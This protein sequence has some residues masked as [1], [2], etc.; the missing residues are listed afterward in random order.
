MTKL[1]P[2]TP[3]P[4]I[5]FYGIRH[6]GPGCARSLL[7]ALNAWNPDCVLIEGPPEA[8]FLLP[9]AVDPEMQPPVALL[10]HCPAEPLLAS[11]Y[12][13]AEFSPEWQA[14]VWAV[15]RG[16]DTRF[17][18]LPQTHG[19][20]MRKARHE[21]EAAKAEVEAKTENMEPAAPAEDLHDQA[22]DPLD[23]LAQAAGYG[24]GES[25]W[26][27]MVEERGDAVDLFA[28]IAEAMHEVRGQAAVPTG[29]RAEREDLREAHMR[30]CIRQAQTQGHQRI[31]VI[32]GAWH[33]PALDGK[34]CIKA[35]AKA[36]ANL[37]KGLPKLKVA[38]TWV[39]WSYPHLSAHSGYGAGVDSPGWYGYLWQHSAQ[40]PQ[41]SRAIGWLTQVAR[42]LREEGL[43]CSSAHVIEGVRLAETVA[44]LRN[45]PAPGL[46]ELNEACV[47]ILCHG[48]QAPLALIEK[49]LIV[50]NK[51]GQIPTAVPAVP[52]Q[53]D[54]EQQQKTLRLKPEALAK[55]L[56][57]DLRKESDLAKSR[58]LHRL[59]LLD[60]AWG[61]LSRTGQSS[62]GTFHEVWQL[63]RQPEF[64][65]NV[66]TASRWGNTLEQ[67]AIAM[68]GSQLHSSTT[69]TELAEL[70]DNVLLANLPAA[71]DAVA[72]A[73]EGRAAVTG[74]SAQLLATLPALANALRYG[75]VRRTDANLLIG[76]FDRIVLRAS[77]GLT[78]ACI[79]LDE[80]AGNAMR[81]NILAANHAIALRK[82]ENVSESWQRA[83]AQ[84][85]NSEQQ[86][87]ALLRGVATRL[88]LDAGQLPAPDAAQ[89]LAR[90]LSSGADPSQAAA[91]L[92]GFLNR[93]ATVLL[94]D[95]TVWALVDGWISGLG[96]EHFI[97]ILPLIRRTFADFETA[98][99][100]DLAG[101]VQRPAGVGVKVAAA[102]AAT[103]WNEER[104]QLPV[105]LLR[106]F[107]GV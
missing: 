26:N 74:D 14:M 56:D 73:L 2:V 93:N 12:P 36:D 69:L 79:A 37:L 82:A 98:E 107:F 75:S 72:Q 49:R 55:T 34:G 5:Q 50:G 23:W 41:A 57:L 24:D 61:T 52:L 80:E 21:K 13:L 44:A 60:I 91:W 92:D 67:A 17:I 88:L 38:A 39:P 71:V 85:A 58:L 100:R 95:E 59:R 106:R 42:L 25:W 11:F 99:R 9:F 76:L 62:K 35:S 47:T 45:R 94:H 20:A 33:V 19:M 51:L 83:L 81:K 70:M 63:Q 96:E 103:I 54:I 46:V 53:Q 6:H 64:A 32:C 101:R 4:S 15:C 29:W 1:S 40:A 78:L 90:N 30:T 66:I 104:A 86:P 10:V 105:P 22:N 48:E 68:A 18:D 27:H 65:L 89:L 43:D 87:A 28:A 77:I 7:Q 97:R 8:D 31:A 102:V 84:L 3:L 16:V